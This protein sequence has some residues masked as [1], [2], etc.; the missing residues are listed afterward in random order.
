MRRT[1]CPNNTL[2]VNGMKIISDEV[3]LVIESEDDGDDDVPS[4]SCFGR[5]SYYSSFRRKSGGRR[6]S[7]LDKMDKRH[8][9]H[10]NDATNQ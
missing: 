7:K 8:S 3:K 1:V 2:A 10:L 9:W 4:D 5:T 6:S